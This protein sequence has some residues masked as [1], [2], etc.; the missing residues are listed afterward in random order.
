MCTCHTHTERVTED[1]TPLSVGGCGGVCGGGCGGVCG[2]GCG[3]V[4]GGGCGEE[5]TSVGI[6]GSRLLGVGRGKE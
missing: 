4:C 3:G 2:G 5:L 1:K 6:S